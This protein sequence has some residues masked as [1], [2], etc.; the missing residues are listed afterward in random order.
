MLRGKNS[1]LRLDLLT[2][3]KGTVTLLFNPSRADATPDIEDGIINL[4]ATQLA[5]D[6]VKTVP[7]VMEIVQERYLTPPPDL[8]Y[9]ATLPSGSLGRCF[10]EYIQKTG[11][12]PNYYRA[13]PITDDTN[14]ILTRLRQTHDIWHLVTGLGSSVNSELGLQAFCLAQIR[15]PLPILLIA[16]GLLRTLFTQP[17]E[18]GL[19]LEQIAIGYR[20]GAKAKPFLAQRWEQNWDKPL[21]QLR[22]YLN[23]TIADE[24]V[25]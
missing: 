8:A 4:K 22:E 7:G 15:I 9:L 10:A 3:L 24:Y 23:V 12:D 16:G 17:E 18:L 20:M 2:T 5:I 19:L 11:F 25:P 13:L 21:D 14:Y 6:Y 1:K